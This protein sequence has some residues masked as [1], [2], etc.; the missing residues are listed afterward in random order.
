MG[1]LRGYSNP[2]QQDDFRTGPATFC[3]EYTFPHLM[4]T[5]SDSR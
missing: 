3:W 2:V 5:P 4:V 1:E